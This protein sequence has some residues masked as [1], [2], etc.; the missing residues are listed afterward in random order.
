MV[1]HSTCESR[2]NG[3]LKINFIHVN[4]DMCRSVVSIIQIFTVAVRCIE[5]GSPMPVSAKMLLN[6][7]RQA[8]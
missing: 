6:L 4:S 5:Q 1:A 7:D 3:V 2:E 8:R